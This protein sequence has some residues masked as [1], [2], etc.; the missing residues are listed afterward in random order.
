MLEKGLNQVGAGYDFLAYDLIFPLIIIG[1]IL[2]ISIP[3]I[4]KI[5]KSK[6]NSAK[7]IPKD[8]LAKDKISKK[9]MDDDLN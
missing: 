8:R 7:R 9:D 5:R 4:I 3:I 6:S 2:G 1:I